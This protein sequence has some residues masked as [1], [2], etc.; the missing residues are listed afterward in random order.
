MIYIY[1]VYVC[2][3]AC[4]RV[5]VCVS[6]LSKIQDMYRRKISTENVAITLKGN[7]TTCVI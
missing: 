4:V 7:I 1:I 5:C 2:G 3:Y 6:R